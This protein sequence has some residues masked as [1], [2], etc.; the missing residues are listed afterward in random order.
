VHFIIITIVIII[1][2][3]IIIITMQCT[4]KAV[5]PDN[6]RSQAST[7]QQHRRYVPCKLLQMVWGRSPTAKSF[8]CIIKPEAVTPVH[9]KENK[10]QMSG[11]S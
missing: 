7:R 2:I 5:T 9:I 1:I 6:D 10:G 8:R 4:K 3:I 11:I